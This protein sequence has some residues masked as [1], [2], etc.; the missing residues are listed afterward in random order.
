VVAC[1]LA[2][3]VMNGWLQNFAYRTEIN[4]NIFLLAGS[5]GLIIA[6]LTVSYQALKAALA[7]PIAAL[8][9]E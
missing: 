4:I 1:P 8:R 7:N 5:L 9:Y 6:W 3:L 2:Y